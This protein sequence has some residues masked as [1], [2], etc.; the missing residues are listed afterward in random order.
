MQ[1]ASED[2]AADSNERAPG[3]AARASDTDGAEE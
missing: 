2:R 1:N 3:H